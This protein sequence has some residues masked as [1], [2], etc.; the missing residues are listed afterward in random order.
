MTAVVPRATY[1][2]LYGPA[3]GDFVA[4]GDTGLTIQVERSEILPGEEVLIGAGRNLRDGLAICPRASRDSALDMVIVSALVLDPVLGI[5]KADIGIKEDRIVGIGQAGNPDTQFGVDMVVDSQ[6]QVLPGAGL[7]ATPGAIDTHVHLN[8]VAQAETFC[9]HGY[10]TLIGASLGPVFDVGIG[11]S[12]NYEN[13]LDAIAAFP[14]NVAMLGRA[15]STPSEMEAHLDVGASGFKIHEDL[16]A[17]PAVIDGSL[18]VSD[19][20]DVQTIIHTDT[21]NE[22][23]TLA[24]TL[25]AIDGRTIHAYHVEGTGG[26]HAPDI[27][28][29][30]GKPNV[31]PSSTNPTNP[32]NQAALREHLDMIMACHLQHRSLYEDLAFA[33]SRIR[34]GT[35]AAEDV[36]HEVGAI[37]MMGSDS[38]GMGRC[39]E[40]IRR[41][42][43]LAAK[44][45]GL[46][47]AP[48][49]HDNERVLRY[50]EKYTLCPALAHGIADHVGSL[51]TGRL[52]DI[53]L[54]N[55]KFFGVK[56][57]IVIKSGVVSYAMTG[58][59]NGSFLGTEP[60]KMR[61]QWGG[62]GAAPRRLAK[63]FTSQLGMDGAKR[64]QSAHL[65]RLLP[66]SGT[67]GIGKA[68]L[69]R[70]A[71]TPD[72]RVDPDSFAVSIDGA[73]AYSPPSEQVPLSR[74]YLLV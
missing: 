51:A 65:P 71:A 16:G 73:E 21:I 8:N 64:R 56:P 19:S 9:R 48:E 74:R 60:V 63:V 36:L 44:M 32:F 17:F 13:F 11:T 53:V 69:S 66:V 49:A 50:L 40:S 57:E 18:S 52:A 58:P 43:Q 39:A 26:G 61:P 1:N 62:T 3:K 30:C 27:L 41:T 10:T 12:Y 54:W 45:K 42:W 15:C 35:M 46:R 47:E 72:V 59:A 6:T 55:P 70:N 38:N 33:Q 5:V 7:I 20:H 25:E 22:S 24:E 23:V 67:R 2:T 34:P 4:L 37:S 68:D 28:E 14:L 29:I 31:L